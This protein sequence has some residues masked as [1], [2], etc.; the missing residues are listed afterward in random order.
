M[1]IVIY[2]QHVLGVGHYFRSLEIC[3]ALQA[4]DVL[5]VSGGPPVEAQVPAH[6]RQLRLPEL[7][8]DAEFSQ[9]LGPRRKETIDQV[10]GRRKKKLLDLV[11]AE[12]PDF[13]IT[14]LYPFG[15]KAF[16][17][18]L[19]PVLGDIRD[20]RLPRCRVVSSVRDILVEKDDAAKHE[21]RVVSTLNG[22]FDAVMVHGDP[23]LIRLEQTFGRYNEIRIPVVYTG[24]IAP[25]A[26]AHAC[27]RLRAALGLAETQRLLVASAGG[28]GVGCRLLEAALK[29]FALM[30]EKSSMRLAV[31]TGPYAGEGELQ[32]L[33]RHAGPNVS[34]ETFTRD[35]LSYLAAADL[36][37][38]MAG[39]NTTMNI[40]ATGVRALVYPFG[41]NREQRLRAQRLADLGALEVLTAEDLEPRRLANRMAAALSVPRRR[42]VAIDLNGAAGTA[43]WLERW[44]AAGVPGEAGTIA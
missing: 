20:G 36:S 25:R 33:Q 11:A 1:K 44:G 8:M 32:R 2:S 42:A 4:H 9:L 38:S 28:G 40:L 19:D 27:M 21:A 5:L 34:V 29:A 22:R 43:A 17:F 37:I 10:K 30:A 6:V 15:R 18:E 14:E 23:H 35:F 12:R 31:F 3:R 7:R 26:P 24:Y 39:Y 16:R 13:F 41:Q